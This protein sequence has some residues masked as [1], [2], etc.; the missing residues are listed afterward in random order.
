MTKR[1]RSSGR[2]T[3]AATKARGT[4]RRIDYSDIADT[5]AEQLKAMRRVGRRSVTNRAD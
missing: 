2:G 1:P 5:S 4:A 3:R